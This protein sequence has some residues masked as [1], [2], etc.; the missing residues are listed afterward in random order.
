MMEED[1]MIEKRN[2]KLKVIGG[3]VGVCVVTFIVVPIIIGS[4]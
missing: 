1:R 2:F 4:D 3:I